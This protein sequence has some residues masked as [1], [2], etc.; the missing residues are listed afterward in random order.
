MTA[1]Q[2]EMMIYMEGKIDAL[3]H[4]CAY[5]VATSSISDNLAGMLRNRAQQKTSKDG[6]SADEQA[7]L[8]G[9]VSVLP[10]VDTARQV[11]HEAGLFVSETST[12]DN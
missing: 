11:V 7:Y 5:L 4:I 12:C 10:D 6:V 3:T 8:K 2:K 9:Y 1:E